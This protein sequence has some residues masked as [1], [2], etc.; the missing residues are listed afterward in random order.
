MKQRQV[1]FLDLNFLE[2]DLNKIDRVVLEHSIVIFDLMEMEI[3]LLKPR[4]EGY[5]QVLNYFGEQFLKQNRELNLI[6][7]YNFIFSSHQ[8]LRIYIFMISPILA[9][10]IVKFLDANKMKNI[11][12][13]SNFFDQKNFG[14]LIDKQIFLYSKTKKGKLINKALDKPKKID[15]ELDSSKIDKEMIKELSMFLENTLS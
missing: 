4:F 12:V 11:L 13:I 14:R 7:F 3:N 8:K 2:I 1:F 9:N 10:E 5:R 6:K 15:L